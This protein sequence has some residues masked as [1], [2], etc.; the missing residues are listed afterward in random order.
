MPQNVVRISTG[1]SEKSTENYQSTQHSISLE[2]DCVIN[3]S[4]REIEEASQKLFA[5]CRKIIG[6]QQKSVSVDS[7]LNVDQPITPVPVTLPPSPAVPKPTTV[8][9]RTNT[10]SSQ[11]LATSK[12]IKYLLQLAKSANLAHDE[13]VTLPATYKKERF[14]QLTSTEASTLIDRFNMKK[15]A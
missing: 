13:I 5:L 12:Q 11:R 4:T 3:G 9:A 1:L 8:P 7:L 10:G 2:M 14:E 15:A 6:A